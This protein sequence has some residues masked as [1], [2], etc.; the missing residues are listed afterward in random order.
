MLNAVFKVYREFTS[1]AGKAVSHYTDL[2][3]RRIIRII[4]FDSNERTYYGVRV[5]QFFP[6]LYY[7][8]IHLEVL[9]AR[10]VK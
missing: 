8:I 1:V 6:K 5:A 3:H 4:I 9:G 7:C 10:R 2:Q